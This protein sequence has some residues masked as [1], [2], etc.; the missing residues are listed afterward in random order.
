[1]DEHQSEEIEHQI[2]NDEVSGEEK[3]SEQD[4]SEIQGVNAGCAS[5]AAAILGFALLAAYATSGRDCKAF[6]NCSCKT[7]LK[8]S[9]ADHDH[10]PPGPMPPPPSMQEPMQPRQIFRFPKRPKPAYE[11]SSAEALSHEEVYNSI[12][13][14]IAKNGALVVTANHFQTSEC[15]R[16]LRYY[17]GKELT[18]RDAMD[19]SFRHVS[20]SRGRY[21]GTVVNVPVKIGR[22]TLNVPIRII[23]QQNLH[24]SGGNS[25]VGNN[26]YSFV[27]LR[28]HTGDMRSLINSSQNL[29]APEALIGLGGC[30]SYGF[31]SQICTPQTP[32]ITQIPTGYSK[33]N[34]Y[35]L[36]RIIDEILRNNSW[37]SMFEDIS[38]FSNVA[39]AGNQD[40]IPGQPGYHNNCEGWRQFPQRISG[41]AIR[42]RITSLRAQRDEWK[43]W[44]R[45]IRQIKQEKLDSLTPLEVQIFDGRIR[46]ANVEVGKFA[47]Q[48]EAWKAKLS[49]RRRSPRRRSMAAPMAPTRTERNRRR[50]QRRRRTRRSRR[51]R[52]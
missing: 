19:L 9:E 12:K 5:R 34:S 25:F 11:G 33:R 45:R 50:R 36:I 27:Q 24:S 3:S 38:R 40:N 4:D 21:V 43:A 8:A 10:I 32:A 46:D 52:R 49:N 30:S 20:D 16:F 2:E 44:R 6:E 41:R 18:D 31:K 1:M 42:R 13:E 37:E 29:K 26:K 47:R 17:S 22:N 48:I 28:G 39:R 51:R 7:K 23:A 35:L 14:N 15:V